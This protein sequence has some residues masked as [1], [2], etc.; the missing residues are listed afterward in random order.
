MR[1]GK[2]IDECEAMPN[3]KPIDVVNGGVCNLQ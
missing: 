3:N 2:N 1:N